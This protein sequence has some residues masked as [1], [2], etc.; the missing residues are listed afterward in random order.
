M[1][2]TG[3]AYSR[4]RWTWPAFAVPGL[5]WLILLFLVP[6]YAILAIAMGRR[7]PIFNT[8]QPV[9]NPLE[10]DPGIFGEVFSDI[11]SGQLGVIF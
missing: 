4:R 8:G 1:S 10:W 2:G 7:D 3:E 6:F 9:W 5:L 11:V